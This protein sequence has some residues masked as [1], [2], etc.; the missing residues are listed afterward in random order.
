M[1]KIA[2]LGTG[3]MGS[4]MVKNLLKKGFSVTVWNRDPRKIAELVKLG[5]VG[6][7]TPRAAVA[8]ADI[9]CSCVT[10]GAA[11]EEVLFGESGATRS[12]K[13]NS[14]LIDFSTI[15]PADA[16]RFSKTATELGFTFLDAPVTGGDVGARDGTLT[17]MLGGDASAVPKVQSMLEALGKRIVYLGPSG[18]GQTTKAINQLV[19][20]VVC[21]SMSEGFAVANRA[22]LPLDK[23][24]EVLVSG[25]AGSWIL[26]KLGS[27]VIKGDFAPGFHIRNM[28]KDLGF[29]LSEAKELSLALPVTEIV[30]GQFRELLEMGFGEEGTQ[31]IVKRYS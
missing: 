25:A 4:S 22:G 7:E 2:F 14:I 27:R 18:A 24:H 3:I 10:D 26:D 6:A 29:S 17:V 11:V 20:A 19:C 31:A 5:A 30:A 12:A 13:P 9:I 23:V 1:D 28:V 21:A 8:E 15:S 16:R